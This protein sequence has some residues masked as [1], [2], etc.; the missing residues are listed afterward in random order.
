MSMERSEETINNV[1]SFYE[2]TKEGRDRRMRYPNG[3]RMFDDSGMMLD[4]KGRRSIFDDVD[5]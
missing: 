2:A 5:E 1:K 4:D 3:Q